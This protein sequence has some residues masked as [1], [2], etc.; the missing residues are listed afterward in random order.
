M[1]LL[2]IYS[3][4]FVRIWSKDLVL[5]ASW[6]QNP[7]LQQ[8]IEPNIEVFESISNLSCEIQIPVSSRH[9]FLKI[10]LDASRV[11]IFKSI[12]TLSVTEMNRIWGLKPAINSLLF[13]TIQSTITH[14]RQHHIRLKTS[15]RMLIIGSLK[16]SNIK[17]KQQP[18]E[19]ISVLLS[20]V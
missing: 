16:N 10:Q 9:L 4:C 14:K 15:S 11:G 2:P 7:L 5:N 12:A 18:N 8:N 3:Q 17:I 20:T 19:F 13:T 6:H 1:A